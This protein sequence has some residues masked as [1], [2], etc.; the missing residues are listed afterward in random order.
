MSGVITHRLEID[1][2]PMH[3]PRRQTGK[4]LLE[5]HPTLAAEP[6]PSPWYG[7]RRGHTLSGRLR[8]GS[9]ESV[10]LVGREQPG[11]ENLALRYLA[12]ALLEAGH[13]PT[14]VPLSGPHSLPDAARTALDASPTVIG[15]SI[16]DADIAIDALAFA[17]LLRSRGF[18]GHITAGGALATLAR[19]ELL[20]RHDDIDSVIRHYGETSLV[21]LTERIG[22]G[23]G[24]RDIPGISTID[25]DG[26]PARVTDRTPLT[27]HPLHPDPLPQLIGVPMARI[28]ASRG[29]PGRCRYCGP[30]ALQRGAL[31]EAARAG[32]DAAT[33]ARAGVGATRRREP[34]D[35]AQEVAE[36]FH[37]RGARFFHVLDDN[38]LSTSHGSGA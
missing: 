17:R 34:E 26:P 32:L 5:W 30:A 27:L 19:Q 33:I 35:V 31:E 10:V 29:C 24:W 36:L 37:Q 11:D 13:H 18:R 6:P 1:Q 28:V 21:E 2:F 25:G 7:R 38:L 12:A 8:M 16:S 20:T 4:V 15:L 22:S 14:I 3:S 23:R 9:R